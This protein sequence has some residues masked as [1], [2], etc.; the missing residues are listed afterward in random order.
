MTILNEAGTRH[1][2]C[3]SIFVNAKLLGKAIVYILSEICITKIM[4]IKFLWRCVFQM[5]FQKIMKSWVIT[6]IGTS[7]HLEKLISYQKQ[8]TY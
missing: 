6:T 5:R 1:T 8:S 2:E 7:Q 4:M 3:S